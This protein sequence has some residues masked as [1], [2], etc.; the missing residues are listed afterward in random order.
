MPGAVDERVQML[1]ELTEV[2]GV[3]G[4]EYEVKD[5]ITRYLKGRAELSG[6]NLGSLI[7]K[8]VGTSTSP[9]IMLPGHMD[10]IGFM[11]SFITEQGYLKFVP[12]GGWWDQVMLAK[13][14]IVR[15]DSGDVPGVIGSKPP[16]ILDPEERKKV[17]EKK[18]MFIDVG[19]SSREEVE[20]VF[21]IRV[22][23]PIVP[24][25]RFQLMKNEKLMMAKAWDDRIGCALFIDVIKELQEV[26]HPNTV[27]G[28]GTVQEEVGLRGAKTTASVIQPDVCIT[29]EVGI[30]GDMPGVKE[31]DAPPKLGRGPVLLMADH[32]LVAHRKLRSLVVETAKESG[33]NLQYATMMGGG[34][35][36]GAV[37]LNGAG[38]PSVCL[39]VP[40]RYI[41]THTGIIHRDDYEATVKLVTEVVK[42]L[43]QET[44][45]G[46]VR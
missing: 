21:G 6:D 34:T 7:A 36:A 11:V 46:L 23:D 25:S 42:R 43:D 10:E 17:V 8:K 12:L 28:V 41:H 18:D 45:N 24:D 37:H 22:G 4:F 3:P 15:T 13:R 44:V 9:K 5:V 20:Q 2:G 19:A 14:V 33:I 35:D 31:E 26:E 30:A 38:V 32:S 29:V 27:Y 1:K 40:A 39:A 16:H